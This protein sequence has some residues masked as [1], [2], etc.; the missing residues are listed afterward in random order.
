MP[1]LLNSSASSPI[2]AL[3]Q[4]NPVVV[5][6]SGSHPTQLSSS[7]GSDVNPKEGPAEKS[8]EIFQKSGMFLSARFAGVSSHTFTTIPPRFTTEKPRSAHPKTAKPLQK[9]P[10]TTPKKNLKQTQLPRHLDPKMLL[11]Q[12]LRH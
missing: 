8:T 3:Q 4:G 7:F 2:C 10:S 5:T 9:R 12:P 6:L 11:S 1:S